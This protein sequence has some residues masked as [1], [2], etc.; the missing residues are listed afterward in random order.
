MPQQPRPA[1][2]L[3][4]PWWCLPRPWLQPTSPPPPLWPRQQR[5][6]PPRQQQQHWQQQRQHPVPLL[7]PMRQS[8]CSPPAPACRRS[9]TTSHVLLPL[10]PPPCLQQ[11]L[12]QHPGGRLAPSPPNPCRLAPS[13][14]STC[15][16]AL[17][18]PSPCRLA[19]TRCRRPPGAP[20]QAALRSL[21]PVPCLCLPVPASRLPLMR[22]QQHHR[23]SAHRCLPPHQPPL[24]PL[25]Q[26]QQQA[27][28]PGR[29]LLVAPTACV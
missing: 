26:Q 29:P 12:R 7:P 21:L 1:L 15:R 19:P 14:P 20:L 16:R 9:P 25:Q 5:Q 11:L 28:V 18:P 22:L 4:L 8:W 2:P 23:P 3:L 27:P 6:R 17:S 13:P 24:L 10:D